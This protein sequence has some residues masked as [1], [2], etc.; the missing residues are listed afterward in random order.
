MT[1]LI[2]LKYFIVLNA[3]FFLF[4]SSWQI[5]YLVKHFKNKKN[6]DKH[7]FGKL[8]Y[9]LL[10]MINLGLILNVGQLFC[11]FLT[12]NFTFTTNYFPKWNLLSRHFFYVIATTVSIF[13]F[14]FFFTVTYSYQ[15]KIVVYFNKEEIKSIFSEYH[16]AGNSVQVFNFKQISL[17]QFAEKNFIYKVNNKIYQ[18][19][20]RFFKC[21]LKVVN[22]MFQITKIKVL[23]LKHYSAAKIN[24]LLIKDSLFKRIWTGLY[25]E[26]IINFVLALFKISR[27]LLIC[28]IFLA[29]VFQWDPNMW[30]FYHY[31]GTDYLLDTNNIIYVLSIVVI[32]IFTVEFLLQN[33]LCLIN[34]INKNYYE[35]I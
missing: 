31:N 23:R 12:S 6:S 1:D 9:I 22:D 5:I 2:S 3:L 13:M 16:L 21:D 11:L 20:I 24:F 28:Y 35:F 25:F 17:I 18:Q 8:F 29:G 19:I 32:I 26:I 27:I 33:L 7:I 4:A 34:L 10:V 14:I 30:L 15:W